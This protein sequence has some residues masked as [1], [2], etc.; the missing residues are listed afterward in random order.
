MYARNIDDLYPR[1]GDKTMDKE[2]IA[3][4]ITYGKQI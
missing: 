2:N 3:L 1:W 4:A